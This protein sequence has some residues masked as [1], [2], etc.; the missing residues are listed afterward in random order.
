MRESDFDEFAGMLDAVCSLLSKGA[1]SPNPGNTALFFRALADRSIDEVRAGFDAH[2]KDQ[3]AG[4]FV[5]SPAD[6]IGQIDA[7]E[8]RDGRPG[9]DEA[10][11]AALLCRDEAETVVW[12]N[13]MSEAWQIAKTVAQAG[14]EIG[15]R[16]AFREAY[17]RLVAEARAVKR[18]PVWLASIGHDVQRRD[19]AIATAVESGRLPASERA[20]LPAPGAPALLDLAE[21]EGAPEHVRKALRELSER[22]RA[23]PAGQNEAELERQRT[24][25]LKAAAK[26]K[27]EQYMSQRGSP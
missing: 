23:R 10:W 24:L 19:L 25:E 15:A 14:D 12:T 16:L 1:Y 18:K 13:E 8:R 9:A 7:A 21:R 11:A 22:L 20:S 26:E 27:A 2:V 4:R 3:K 17:Q 6:I 5:P